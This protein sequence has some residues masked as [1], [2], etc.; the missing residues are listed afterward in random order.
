MLQVT[1][2]NQSLIVNYIY[3]P[4]GQT[5]DSPAGA[6]SN[7]V[8]YTGREQDTA[9]LYYYRNRYYSTGMDRF[10]SEDPIGLAGGNLY[11]YVGGNPVGNVDST[12]LAPGCDF[13][14]DRLETP[15]RLI[16]CTQH[17]RCWER[18]GCNMGSWCPKRATPAYFA[19]NLAV[20][21]C[22]LRCGNKR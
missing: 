18:H 11:T 8:R 6:S 3:G 17:D 2:S 10:I 20:A 16:C 22:F 5:T 9:N 15:C 4:Y 13:I 19:C 12:G 21:E 1:A 14:P 7:L